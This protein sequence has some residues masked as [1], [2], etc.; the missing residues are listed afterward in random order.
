MCQI[1]SSSEKNEIDFE[2]IL[3]YLLSSINDK[4]KDYVNDPSFNQLMLIQNYIIFFMVLVLNLKKFPNFIKIIFEGHSQFFKKLCDSIFAMKSKKNKKLLSII[5]NIFLEEYKDIFFRKPSNEELENMFIIQQTE[6]S[7][8]F[9]ETI[10][11]YDESTYR[12]MFQILLDFDIS[13]VNF[14]TYNNKIKEEDKSAYKLCIAQ[15]LIR[16]A[17]SK[18][19]KKFYEKEK[20]Y[21]YKLLKKIINKDMK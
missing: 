6:F 9:L 15:S 1:L 3:E 7:S 8:K 17:F 14:F 5:N 13:Y 2:Q 20:F 4:I 21:E 10:T 18:E 16:V 19:K 12:K 11:F